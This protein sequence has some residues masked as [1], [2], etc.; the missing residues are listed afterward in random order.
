MVLFLVLVLVDSI[1]SEVPHTH[2]ALF[3]P[4]VNICLKR[5]NGKGHNENH[6]S[7]LLIKRITGGGGH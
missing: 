4:F 1:C 3:M 2:Y 7:G 5:D 6:L